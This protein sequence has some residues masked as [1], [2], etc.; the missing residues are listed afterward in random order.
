MFD[1]IK[2]LFRKETKKELDTK[3]DKTNQESKSEEHYPYEGNYT[4]TIISK[5]NRRISIPIGK[6]LFW[7]S[8]S[9]IHRNEYAPSIMEEE[10]GAFG[11]FA[12]SIDD[13][14]NYFN[15]VYDYYQDKSYRF[16]KDYLLD[17]VYIPLHECTDINK[18]KCASRII[19]IHKV[20]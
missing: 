5:S 12:N 17:G 11:I 20:E 19:E 16:S 10:I 7:T 9:Y 3:D 4:V 8:V 6:K 15:E 13:V 2:R 18:L 1:K 14:V